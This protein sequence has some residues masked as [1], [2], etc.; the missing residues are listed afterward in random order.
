VG[1]WADD[2]SVEKR[3]PGQRPLSQTDY[4]AALDE[5]MAEK[6][7]P[8]NRDRGRD[9]VPGGEEAMEN[10]FWPHERGKVRA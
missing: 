1:S 9:P 5:Q 4:R 8:A 3:W 6:R 10:P 2:P 7:W